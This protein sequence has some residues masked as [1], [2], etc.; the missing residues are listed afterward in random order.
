MDNLLDKARYNPD[1]VEQTRLWA[2]AQKKIAQDAVSIQLYTQY[3][4]MARVKT[5]EL[6]H[7]QKSFSF[8]QLTEK[9]KVLDR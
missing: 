6:G 3:Y 9:S 8:Y 7:A 5:L 1:P 2:E 4:A